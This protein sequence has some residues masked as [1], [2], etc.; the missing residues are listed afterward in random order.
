MTIAAGVEEVFVGQPKTRAFPGVALLR[1]THGLQRLTLVVGLI[2]VAGFILVALFAPLLPGTASPKPVPTV[3]ISSA[4]RRRP[5]SI[6]SAPR[7]AA[8]TCT[9]G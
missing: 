5:R 1:S 3:S 6:G 8:R 4:N 9:R 7:S 2:L